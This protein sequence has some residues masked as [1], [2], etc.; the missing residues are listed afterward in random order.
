MELSQIIQAVQQDAVTV[1]FVNVLLQQL[2]LPVPAVPTLLLAGSLAATPGHL[3]QVLA[4]AIVAS[5][6]ADW[7]WYRAG[8]VFG[9]RALAGLCKLSINPASC[10]SQTEARFIRWG[11]SS[12]VVA[13]FVPGFSTVAPPI[14]G[15]LRMHLP[16][17][18][19]AAG[20]GACLWAG[21][22][23]G[24]GWLLKDE[25]QAAI[26]ALDR[27][28]GTAL[29]VV[30]PLI[31]AWLGWKLWQKYRFR[32]SSTVPHITPDE[33]IEALRS[34]QP[35]LILDLRG[36]TMIAETDAVPGAKVAEH[37][38]LDD[39]VGDWPRSRP[40]V[41]LCACPEDAG[42]IAAARHLLDDGY[43]SVRVLQGG[44][45]AWLAA[46]RNDPP[47]Q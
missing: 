16:G 30:L 18:L 7:L 46:T 13:K 42:A 14:A 9:Y 36:A 35:P 26:G 20:A 41:T 11:L 39:A 10:V 22:A 29:A 25:V 40:I 19:M 24:A 3:G 45:D 38:R 21:L 15:A 8:R 28:T 4:A 43:L 31:G 27:H 32:R 23:L 17:F 44:Y 1:V 12:I 37:D 5:V 33:L 6:I 47:R 2:G 34:Q